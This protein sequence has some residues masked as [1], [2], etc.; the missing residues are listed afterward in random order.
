M[1]EANTGVSV[2]DCTHEVVHSSRCRKH[3]GWCG[4][5]DLCQKWVHAA[6]DMYAMTGKEVYRESKFECSGTE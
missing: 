1:E 5:C 3:L 2:K 6:Y 4:K